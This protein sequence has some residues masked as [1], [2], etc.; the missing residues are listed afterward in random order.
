MGDGVDLVEDNLLLR[1]ITNRL[2]KIELRSNAV[3]EIFN[4]FAKFDDKSAT[5]PVTCV[6]IAGMLPGKS[7]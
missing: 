7:P 4:T 2:A 5:W 3:E 1:E 6:F